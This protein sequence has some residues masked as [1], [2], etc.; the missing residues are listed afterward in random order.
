MSKHKVK[1][2]KWIRGILEQFNFEFNSLK[3]AQKFADG[4][5]GHSTK[6]YNENDELVSHDQ[7]EDVSTSSY[8]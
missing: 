6:I 7:S 8:A 3:E 4:S 2:H 1:V 5:T